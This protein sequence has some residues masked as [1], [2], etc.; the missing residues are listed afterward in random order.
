MRSVRVGDTA[1]VAQFCDDATLLA[2]IGRS[3]CSE[4]DKG[5]A[6]VCIA[7]GTHRRLLEKQLHA[8]GISVVAA[9]AS[10][11]Y[12]ILNALEA[13]SRIL[14]DDL[15][16]V[17][18]FAEVVGA[19]IDRVAARH[20]RVLIFGELVPLMRAEGKHAGAVELGKLWQSFVGSR[21]IFLNCEYPAYA[22]H[23]YSAYGTIRALRV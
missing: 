23:S 20:Q 7:T 5:N 21:P 9:Q 1:A 12:V 10:G 8:H 15:P 16:D 11:R 22:P 14:V 19:L 4:L 17:I 6:V 2:D 13:L 18:R 3:M